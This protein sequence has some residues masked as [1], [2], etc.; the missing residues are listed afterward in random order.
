MRRQGFTL[1]ELLVVIAIIAILAAILFP[2]FAQARGA[3]RKAACLSNLK[4]LG[5]AELMYVNDYDEAFTGGSTYLGVA[6]GTLDAC[7]GFRWWLDLIQPYTKSLGVKVCPSGK[8]RVSPF[9]PP[10]A[11]IPG[12]A[13]NCDSGGNPLS[14]TYYAS[15]AWSVIIDWE[16]QSSPN[17]PGGG[18][19]WGVIWGNPLKY[20]GIRQATALSAI[21]LPAECIMIHDTGDTYIE[22]WDPTTTDLYRSSTQPTP[23]A[24]LASMA[25]TRHSDG[26]CSAYV[27]GHVKYSRRGGT[28]LQN[29]VVQEVSTADNAY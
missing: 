26:F 24:T 27:D 15:Y 22:D 9:D 25:Y 28:K 6:T 8:V 19:N 14:G 17:I 21:V 3:A 13:G 23:P 2:V 1:I 10:L 12:T 18:T 7:G 5:L 4:Q 16:T 29:W 11:D 20:W